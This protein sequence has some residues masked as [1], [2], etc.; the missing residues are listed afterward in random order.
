M[1]ILITMKKI[2]IIGGG[3]AGMMAAATLAERDIDAHVTLIERNDC[4]GMKVMISG[5]G[6]CNVT[7]GNN[8]LKE[9]LKCY[10][11]G[12][13]F[14]K[15]PMY[16]FKPSDVV[17][18]IGGRGVPLKTEAD[19]RVFPQSDNGKDIMKLYEK[20]LETGRVQILY[21]TVVTGV[22]KDEKFIVKLREREDLEADSVILTTGGQAYRR[23]GSKGDGYDFAEALGHSIT[24][25][26]P[27]LS[28]YM[29]EEEWVKDL[30]GVSFENVKLKF[31]KED[32]YEF[33]GPII[34]THRGV[35]G[36]AVFALN[37]M[38][39]FE[40]VS[41]ED[42]A[43]LFIDFCPDYNHEELRDGFN[44]TVSKNPKKNVEN[45]NPLPIPKSLF[46]KFVEIVGIN[47]NANELSKK[48]INKLIEM[49]KNSELTLIGT[50]PG[51]EFVTAGGV[52]L[53]EVDSK[54]ME[55][56]ICPGLYFAGEILNIDGFTGGYNLQVAWCTGRLAGFSV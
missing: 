54:T 7:T 34:L 24:D 2:I 12:A 14:L 23:T 10:P 6:R 28:S 31:V 44:D 33:S 4:L 26:A 51:D 47:K 38:A 40:K 41:K 9:V 43:S 39:A 5:G 55:S 25:L 48:E 11:R 22:S 21:K 16:A 18:W 17:D 45:I 49:A 42:P 52:E 56:K 1:Y 37:S 32:K 53:S 35:S 30:S 15:T 29:T 27:S 50:T 36:P 3:A 19:M 8:E 46:K 13:R 20:I